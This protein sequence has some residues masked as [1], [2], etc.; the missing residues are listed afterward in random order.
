[1]T[2]TLLELVYDPTTAHGRLAVKFNSQQYETARQW[3]R[4]NIATLAK[5]KNNNILEVSSMSPSFT[6][7]REILRDDNVLE[8]EFSVGK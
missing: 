3:V 2:I 1:M 6:I 4:N 8:V 5:D 7:G